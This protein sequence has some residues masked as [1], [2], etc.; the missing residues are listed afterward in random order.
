MKYK[1]TSTSVSMGIKTSK[2]KTKLTPPLY[3]KR[4]FLGEKLEYL[5]PVNSRSLRA[6]RRAKKVKTFL[7]E[8]Y[9][10]LKV[11]MGVAVG[12]GILWIIQVGVTSI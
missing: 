3:W 1:E 4:G 2:S 11:G 9:D 5:K 8:A 7:K 6:E 10:V 12:V